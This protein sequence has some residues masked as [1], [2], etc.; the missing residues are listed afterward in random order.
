MKRCEACGVELPAPVE[1]GK[2]PYCEKCEAWYGPMD[3]YLVEYEKEA[4]R[5]NFWEDEEDEF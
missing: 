5:N 2:R 4:K 1:P 3:D